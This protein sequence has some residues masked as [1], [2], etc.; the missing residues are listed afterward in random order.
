MGGSYLLNVGPDDRGVIT[1]EYVKKLEKIGNWYNRME[2]CLEDNEPEPF[3][4]E[5]QPIRGS[6]NPHVVTRKNGKTY[7]HFYQGLISDHFRLKNWPS[8]PK[9]ARLLNTGSMLDF[10]VTSRRMDEPELLDIYHIPVDDT[11]GEPLVIE[12]EWS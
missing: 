5:V 8:M 6:I 7:F 10:A 4:Y 11:N 1:K 12:V 2:G 3:D 9:S